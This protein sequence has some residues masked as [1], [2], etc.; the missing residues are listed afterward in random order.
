MFKLTG[1]GTGKQIGGRRN[2]NATMDVRSYEA[3]QN[4][5]LQNQGDKES[6][7]ISK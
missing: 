2:E 5:K 1:E 3:E 6:G 7:E 4:K